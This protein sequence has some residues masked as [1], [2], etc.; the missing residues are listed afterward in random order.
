M[1]SV[2]PLVGTF[3]RYRCYIN[4]YGDYHHYHCVLFSPKTNLYV[5]HIILKKS[6]IVNIKI[7][8]VLE[9]LLSITS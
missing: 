6:D 9:L 2:A 4:V 5:T 7:I 1:L 3:K 8:I